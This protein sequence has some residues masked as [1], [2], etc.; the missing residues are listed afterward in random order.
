LNLNYRTTEQIRRFADRILGDYADDSTGE[1]EERKDEDMRLNYE[2]VGPQYF[3]T[4]RTP[5]L[6]GR[7][8]DERDDQHARGMVIINET[9]AQRYWPRGDA[10]GRRLRLD[11]GWLEIVG[12]ARDV[13]NRTLNETPKPFLY[14]P[15]LQDYRSNMIL[16][17]RTAAEPEKM[18]HAV[19]AEVAALDPQMPMFDTKTFEEH[20]GISRFLERMAATL[21]SIF[22]LLALSLAAVGLYGV[23]AYT[24]SQ[25]TRE[26]GIRISIGQHEATF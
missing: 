22:G 7:D 10:L 1:A 3:Q 13:K 18:F 21:L 14:L 24:V 17:V 12:I 20:I 15:F 11:K 25:R 2:T 23:M 16:V 26:F 5:L 6:H 8:F 4:M 9:M 19:R